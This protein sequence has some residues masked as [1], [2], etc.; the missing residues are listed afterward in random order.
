MDDFPEQYELLGFFESEPEFTDNID[1]VP[2]Y[3]NRMTYSTSRGSDAIYC[4]IELASGLLNLVWE[5]SGILV[6]SLHLEEIT[7]LIV[8]SKNGEDKLIAKFGESSGLLDF[9]L[10][11]KPSVHVKWGNERLM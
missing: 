11:L 9:E 10:Q 5:K 4:V 6:S 3:Y 1:E 8:T 7:S 2:F